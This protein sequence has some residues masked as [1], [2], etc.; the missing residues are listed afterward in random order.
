M[1]NELAQAFFEIGLGKRKKKR[2]KRFL[3]ETPIKILIE[4]AK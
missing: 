2:K 4:L 3:I 1:Q